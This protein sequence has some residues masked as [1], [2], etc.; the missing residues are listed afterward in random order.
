MSGLHTAE[1][2]AVRTLPAV[3][4]SRKQPPCY[5]TTPNKGGINSSR[6]INTLALEGIQVPNFRWNA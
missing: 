4:T 1:V 5:S 6:E 2:L 3:A